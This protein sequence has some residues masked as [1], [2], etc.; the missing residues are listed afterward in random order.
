[1]DVIILRF[2]TLLLNPLPQLNRNVRTD[3]GCR[4]VL[5]CVVLCCAVSY[6]YSGS[7]ESSMSAEQTLYKLYVRHKGTVR[8]WQIHVK[9]MDAQRRNCLGSSSTAVEEKRLIFSQINY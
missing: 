2:T 7:T 1:M 4:A 5:C 6:L 8:I 9:G 3:I